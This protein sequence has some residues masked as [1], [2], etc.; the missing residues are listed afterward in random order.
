[1]ELLGGQ[2][3]ELRMA[4]DYSFVL[5]YSEGDPHDDMAHV[6]ARLAPF[7]R[8]T[9]KVLEVLVIAAANLVERPS[10][11]RAVAVIRDALLDRTT[12]TEA[13]AKALTGDSFTDDDRRLVATWLTIIDDEVDELFVQRDALFK[14]IR[15]DLDKLA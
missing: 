15:E 2:L 12:L 9:D 8:L 5:G 11:M 7:G 3:A 1:M 13:D 14:K 10:V 4:G 6:R